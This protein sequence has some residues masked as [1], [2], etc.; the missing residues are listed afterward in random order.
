MKEYKKKTYTKKDI[1][2]RSAGSIN[3]TQEETKEAFDSII[4]TLYSML[5]ED[6]MS[7]RIEVRNL[8]VFSLKYAKSKPKARNPKTNEIVFVP[9]HRKV[10]FK[11]SKRIKEVLSK[12]WNIKK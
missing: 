7:L 9:N 8:G 2:R 12:E 5:T 11:P 4:E 3:L 10:H 6:K 1:I